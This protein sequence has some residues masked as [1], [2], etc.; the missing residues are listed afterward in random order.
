MTAVMQK[1]TNQPWS[2]MPGWGIVADLTPP[3]L[4]ASRRLRVIRKLIALGAVVLLALCAITW[5][6]AYLQNQTASSALASETS[7]TAT[8]QA[9]QRRY[10]EVTRL[11]TDLTQIQAQL[12]K[13]LGGDV[14]FAPL[15]AGLRGSLRPGMTI[16]QVSMNISGPGAAAVAS[17]S[18]LDTSGHPHIGTMS[19]TGT[20]LKLND[21]AAFVDKLAA[22]PGF[23]DVLAPSSQ[24]STNGVQYSI[25]ASFTDEV[26]S[27]QFDLQKN[28]G[29]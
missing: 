8:L 27:H 6:Y 15:I 11:Q 18:T 22:L 23:V 25:T 14:S 10:S 7:R 24:Q 4:I 3:E 19:L 2:S 20:A 13:L 9:E 28:G 1:Q 5:G 26:L 21:V 12:S 29:K 17:G 16:A